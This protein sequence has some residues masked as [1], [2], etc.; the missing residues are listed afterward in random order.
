MLTPNNFCAAISQCL[1]PYATDN[2]VLKIRA[3]MKNHFSFLGI[4][5]PPR[6]ALNRKKRSTLNG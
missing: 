1:A 6:R 5:T 2:N 4:P 3:Y